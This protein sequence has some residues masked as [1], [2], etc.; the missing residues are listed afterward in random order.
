[1]R[2][3]L[4]KIAASLIV[5]T[6]LGLP[7][8]ARTVEPGQLGMKYHA[9]RRPGLDAEIRGE[10]LYYQ[11]NWND[12]IVYDVTWQS[13]D[14]EIDV[15]TAD[16][17]H[18]PTIV[19]IAFRPKR[20][21]LYELHTGIGPD[22]Y[23]EVIRPSF[24]TIV[25]AEF[26]RHKHNDL[27]RESPEIERTVKARMA[28]ILE[29]KPLEVDQVSIK[30]IAFDA[31][32]TQ[33]ISQKLSTEQVAEQKAFEIQIAKQDAEIARTRAAGEADAVRIRAEGAAAATIINGK[34][35]SEAQGAITETLTKEYLQYKAFDNDS[36]T[37][38]FVP[39]GRDGLPIIVNTAH[40]GR[41]R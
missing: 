36:T 4:W 27:A 26:S 32:V 18:V 9:L 11:W 19:T 24:M 2:T 38:Y 5:A 20:D 13:R 15:L 41:A 7:A 35:Q 8:C 33:S 12:V 14:E 37:Y 40:S 39:V 30:H 28:E 29:S 1:M 6:L 3:H 17:L 25:R 23:D 31:R 22:Y 21:E 10:G 34:A 16:D